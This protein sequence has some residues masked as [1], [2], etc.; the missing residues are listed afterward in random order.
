MES[1]NELVSLGSL[2]VKSVDVVT[3]ESTVNEAVSR[4]PGLN[5]P[6]H[7]EDDVRTS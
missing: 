4:L 5:N 1:G 2:V 3:V 7:A 6:S